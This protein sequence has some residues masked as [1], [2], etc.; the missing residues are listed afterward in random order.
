MGFRCGWPARGSA[1]PDAGRVSLPGR[2]AVQETPKFLPHRGGLG[3]AGD[4]LELSHGNLSAWSRALSSERSRPL[5][6]KVGDPT[7]GPQVVLSRPHPSP[8]DLAT[9]GQKIDPS[10]WHRTDPFRAVT[11]GECVLAGRTVPQAG[12]ARPEPG[13]PLPRSPRQNVGG[14]FTHSTRATVLPGLR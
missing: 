2:P 9:W 5:A 13:P 11:V 10:R 3:F 8:D 4:H 14:V 6:F 7:A 12:Y 1:S